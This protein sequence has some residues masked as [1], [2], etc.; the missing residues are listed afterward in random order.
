MTKQAKISMLQSRIGTAGELPG[1]QAQLAALKR[2]TS[3][4]YDGPGGKT[5]SEF[6]PSWLDKKNVG[7]KWTADR[8]DYC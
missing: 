1:D 2:Q 3:R 8:E 6:T 5:G 4:L 7:Y